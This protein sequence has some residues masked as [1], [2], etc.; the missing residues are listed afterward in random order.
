MPTAA[1]QGLAFAIADFGSELRLVKLHW[2]SPAQLQRGVEPCILD[3]SPSK[4][5]YLAVVALV[6]MYTIW[7]W[8]LKT[9]T[10]WLWNEAGMYLYRMKRG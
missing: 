4:A 10:A 7:E 1:T 2:K 9:C 8:L 6:A 5:G 3:Q